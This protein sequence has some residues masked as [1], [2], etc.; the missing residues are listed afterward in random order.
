MCGSFSHVAAIVV[1]LFLGSVMPV[2]CYHIELFLFFFF[3]WLLDNFYPTM[4]TF[5]IK[6]CGLYP[7]RIGPFRILV[8]GKDLRSIVA[9]NTPPTPRP[10]E[11]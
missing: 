5:F 7:S 10:I 6:F 2:S 11:L 1:I 8:I 3:F 4:G 9:E